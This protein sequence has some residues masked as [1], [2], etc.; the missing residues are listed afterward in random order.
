MN[1]V[2]NPIIVN[3]GEQ[4][5]VSKTIDDFFLETRDFIQERYN[6]QEPE[7][8][9]KS[10]ELAYHSTQITDDRITYLSYRDMI[11][12]SVFETRTEFNYVRYTF[13]RNLEGFGGLAP[14]K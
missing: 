12:A 7:F 9:I 10:G 1:P 14:K 5:R 11:L 6:V 2:P 8:E 13:F 3:T 4:H